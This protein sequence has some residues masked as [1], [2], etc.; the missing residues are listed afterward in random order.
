MKS[1]LKDTN[2]TKYLTQNVIWKAVYRS[3]NNIVILEENEQEQNAEKKDV[4]IFPCYKLDDN[5]SVIFR[6]LYSA[7]FKKNELSHT[8]LYLVTRI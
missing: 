3:V 2:S 5:I 1:P 4:V 7:V 6:S 8:I